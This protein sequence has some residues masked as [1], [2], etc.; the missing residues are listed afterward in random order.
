MSPAGCNGW[1]ACCGRG[2]DGITEVVAVR[3]N[4]HDLYAAQEAISQAL[5]SHFRAVPLESSIDSPL[6]AVRLRADRTLGEQDRSLIEQVV[7]DSPV[8]VRLSWVD[9]ASLFVELL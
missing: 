1:R 6:N 9:P 2:V 4:L 5:D 8:D 3:S 7:R